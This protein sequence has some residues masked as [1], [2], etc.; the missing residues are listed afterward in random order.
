MQE[1]GEIMHLASSGRVIIRLKRQLDEGNFVCDESGRKIAKVAELIGP[2]SN[3]YA[4]A[5]S[6]TNNIK[7]Y[8]GTK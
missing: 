6:L 2:V 3:P 8:V 4:S 1:V 5:I 7:K